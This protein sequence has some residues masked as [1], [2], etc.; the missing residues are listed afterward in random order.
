MRG[1]IGKKIGMTQ[2]FDADGNCIP[3]TVIKLGPCTVVR[4]KTEGG[5]DGYSALLL[6]YGE[7]N[8]RNLNKPEAGLFKAAGVKPQ[9][10]L[11]EFRVTQEENDK[12]NVGDQL[13]CSMFSAGDY[14]DVVG[15]SKGRGFE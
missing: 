1:L 9:A 3:V 2:V 4:K 15:T 10:S 12:V 14:V 6:G 7:T 13:D 8:G 5:V 11:K